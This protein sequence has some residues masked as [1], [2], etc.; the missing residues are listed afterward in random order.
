MPT[1]PTHRLILTFFLLIILGTVAL[2]WPGSTVSGKELNWVDALFTSTSAVCVTGLTVVDTGTT[3]TC[4]GQITI[5]LLIQLGGLGMLTISNWVFLTL[6]RGRVSLQNRILIEETHG[7]LPNIEPGSLLR[8]IIAFTF[9]SES[10]GALV[11]FFRF[12]LDYPMSQALWSAVFHSVAAFCNAG[13]SL[14][15][16]SLSAYRDDWLVCGT[17]MSL[18]VLGGIGF[19]VCSDIATVIHRTPR[20]KQWEMKQV[21]RRLAYHTKV[22]LATT[23]VLIGIGTALTMGLEWGNT[24]AELPWYKRLLPSLFL[25]ITSRTAGFN[26]IDTGA[27]TNISLFTF[28]FFM[29]VGASPGSTG[30]GIKTTTFAVLAALVGSRFRNRPRV[31]LLGRSI[32]NDLVTKTFTVTGA[33]IV[34]DMLAVLALET[35]EYG[36]TS[37]RVTPSRFLDI[38]FEVTSAIGT[39]GLSTGITA[40]LQAGSRLVLV[41]CMFLGRVGPLVVAGSVIGL[42][43]PLRYS[44]PEERFMVG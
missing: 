34:I 13:F 33:F 18:I 31:E 4:R 14:Y 3:F 16:D 9:L 8:R 12:S 29:L 27:L 28:V 22:V 25:S 39:V 20:I 21:W 23:L 30:G 5:L 7:T 32:P 2:H 41:V 24:L 38:I 26:T 40:E 6:T 17:V 36:L 44:L 35:I 11:L 1:H 15:S 19:V 10:L 42:R 37:H 43:R